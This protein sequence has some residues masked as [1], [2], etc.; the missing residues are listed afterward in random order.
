M[1]PD[2][3]SRLESREAGVSL[4]DQ[5]PDADLFRIEVVTDYLED[6]T[7][8]LAIGKCLGEYTTT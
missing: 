3:I 6:I 5:F 2:H 4:N 1:G 8:F 7:L